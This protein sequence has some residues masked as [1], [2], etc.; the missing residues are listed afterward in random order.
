MASSIQLL[1]FAFLGLTTALTP[2]SVTETHPK[3]QTWKC[4]LAGGCVSQNTALVIDELT[5]P[6]HQTNSTLPCATA[7]NTLNS[8]VC[9]DA[10]TCAKNC[11]VDGISDYTKYG[12]FANGS[13]VEMHQVNPHRSVLSPRLY[14]LGEGGEEYEMLKLTGQELSFDVDSSA[15]PCGMNGALYLSEMA[16]DGGKSA[17]NTA[18]AKYGSGYCDA[19]CHNLPVINGVVRPPFHFLLLSSPAFHVLG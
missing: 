6:I 9:P 1:T 16:A 14:V 2:S 5:H 13:S 4:T 8:T 10:A 11:A 7:S 18:G 3:L 15:L 19:Q 12:V 17:L